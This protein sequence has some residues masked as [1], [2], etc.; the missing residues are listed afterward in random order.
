MQPIGR[1]EWEPADLRSVFLFFAY[2]H[3][4]A[5]FLKLPRRGPV[6]PCITDAKIAEG[7][8]LSFPNVWSQRILSPL[9]DCESE[10]GY[11]G[12]ARGKGSIVH[13]KTN[14]VFTAESKENKQ[15]FCND[16]PPEKSLNIFEYLKNFRWTWYFQVSLMAQQ[17]GGGGPST[18]AG[19]NLNFLFR[20][21]EIRDREMLGLSRY[22]FDVSDN[23]G[24][25]KPSTTNL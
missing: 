10:I 15:I 19:C 5:S 16:F 8:C 23:N 14:L 4:L 21:K 7:L 25:S 9:T 6:L 12:S 24:P 20:S 22:L 18:S 1:E 11:L 2:E 13:V 3:F 17:S